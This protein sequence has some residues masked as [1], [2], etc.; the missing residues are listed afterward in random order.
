M[1]DEEVRGGSHVQECGKTAG[2][3]WVENCPILWQP[4][5]AF[6]Y[7]LRKGVGLEPLGIP[8][9]EHAFGCFY[10]R[11]GLA[12]MN[13]L[14]VEVKDVICREAWR[15]LSKS[16]RVVYEMNQT[17]GQLNDL[18]VT[19]LNT[20]KILCPFLSSISHL[21]FVFANPQR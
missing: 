13:F 21:R 15:T 17:Q 5:V 11:I 14:V 7:R 4:Q 1:G 8:R 3:L 18:S 2:S 16:V 6:T 19:L 20:D 10:E 12:K 9:T